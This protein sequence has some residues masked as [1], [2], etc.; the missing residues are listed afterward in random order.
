MDMLQRSSLSRELDDIKRLLQ[1]LAAARPV[2]G[3]Q[4]VPIVHKTA[5]SGGAAAKKK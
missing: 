5:A 2:S 4:D 3:H 1:Q